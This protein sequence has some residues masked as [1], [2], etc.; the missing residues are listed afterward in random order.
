MGS[1]C[2]IDYELVIGMLKQEARRWS[3]LPNALG[4]S[5]ER[6]EQKQVTYMILT[7]AVSGEETSEY[8]CSYLEEIDYPKAVPGSLPFQIQQGR[9]FKV[10][11]KN[12]EPKIG[13]ISV[14]DRIIL[15]LHACGRT[16]FEWVE[17][18]GPTAYHSNLMTTSTIYSKS[19]TSLRWAEQI[20]QSWSDLDADW[21][22]LKW[23]LMMCLRMRRIFGGHFE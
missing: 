6:M 18:G 4:N 7:V 3:A 12:D 22:T 23:F 20:A 2:S 10:A 19:C 21:Q 9:Y 11:G 14:V 1:S 17:V 5:S 16:Q 13:L 15:I 8:L